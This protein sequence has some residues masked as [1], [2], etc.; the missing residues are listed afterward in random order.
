M[1]TTIS[2]TEDVRD[3]LLKVAS[4]LQIKLG[5]RV[6]LNEAI[7]FLL[8]K[9]LTKPELFDRA[10]QPETRMKGAYEELIQERRKDE[11]RSKR[12]YGI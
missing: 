7:E 6:D 12:R 4:E 10:C 2:V 8:S 1:T 5:R 9:N 3:K 11:L